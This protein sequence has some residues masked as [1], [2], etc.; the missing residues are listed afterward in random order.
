MAGSRL[1]HQQHD[2]T[3]YARR[4]TTGPPRWPLIALERKGFKGEALG[5]LVFGQEYADRAT[6]VAATS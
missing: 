6:M 2:T 5:E 3:G 4:L 1:R